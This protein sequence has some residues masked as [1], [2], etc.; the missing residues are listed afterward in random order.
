[1]YHNLSNENMLAYFRV[2]SNSDVDVII[3][4]QQLCLFELLRN[5]EY[6]YDACFAQAYVGTFKRFLNFSA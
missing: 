2:G 3:F 4:Q 1:M 6:V 5:P